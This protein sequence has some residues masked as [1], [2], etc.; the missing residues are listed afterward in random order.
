LGLLF[1]S[2]PAFAAGL[3][4]DF[5]SDPLFSEGN[6]SPGDL[7]EKWVKVTNTSGDVRTITVEAINFVDGN[8]LGDVLGIEVKDGVLSLYD[9]TLTNF[10]G[11]GQ[12][13]LGDMPTGTNKVYDF[14]ISFLTGA[15]NEYQ[16]TELGFDIIVGAEGE[17]GVASGGGGGVVLPRGLTIYNEGE[18]S[19]ATTTVTI[20]WDTSYDSTS[21]VIYSPEG[22]SRTLD[23]YATNYGYKF[24]APDPEDTNKVKS[25]S[26]TISGLTPGVTYYYRCVSRA[27]PATI[28]Q[29]HSFTTLAVEAPLQPDTEQAPETGGAG[30]VPVTLE[31]EVS[32]GGEII[33][34]EGE[35][36]DLTGDLVDIV[37]DL[38]DPSTSLRTSEQEGNNNFGANLK[39]FIMNIPWW[40]LVIIAFILFLIILLTRK[41]KDK[42]KIKT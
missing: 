15:E 41:K 29:E 37:E 28:G 1:V 30:V 9:D 10:F 11:A 38:I 7:V 13:G 35:G 12:I 21:Q 2:A 32:P 20:L 6:F 40:I 22:E 23:L 8:G 24:A 31:G 3:A 26:V 39:D 25:H 5:E 4:V 34:R 16:A 36:E 33:K 14:I 18:T 19:A 17:E 42:E 27:S